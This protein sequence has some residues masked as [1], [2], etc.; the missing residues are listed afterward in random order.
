MSILSIVL[1]NLLRRPIRSLLTVLGVAIG[2]AAVVSL[3]SLVWGFERSWEAVNR[4]R[5][6]DVV[7]VRSS[8]RSL[9]PA[10]FPETAAGA[11]AGLDGVDAASGVLHDLM[12]IE[13]A[14]TV[15]VHGWRRES[16]LWDHLT[17]E[18]G[19]WPEDEEQVVLLGTIAAET[20]GKSVGD[21]VQVDMDEFVVCGVFNSTAAS[22]RTA[23][24][25]PLPRLQALTSR[26]GMINVV[27]VRM[28]GTVDA[29]AIERLRGVIGAR[30]GDGFRVFDATEAAQANIGLQLAKAVSLGTS[31][32]AAAVGAVGV[33][34]TVLM[35]VFERLREIGVLLALGW[36]RRRI[37]LMILLES[38]LLSGLGAAAGI[39]IGV[40]SV[41]LLL[42]TRALRGLI[43]AGTEPLVLVSVV[44]IALVIGALGGLY[45]AWRGASMAPTEALRHE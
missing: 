39:V 43:D 5:G 1:K 12:S 34:N 44:G 27:N 36:R 38:L 10:V 31:V 26:E 16:F 41:R 17:L 35:S 24:I 13:E 29:A 18:H 8:G 14:P 2:I 19:R 20:L 15:L 30:L 11:V 9:L 7:V 45:P 42:M 22:E 4:A 37:V 6:T 33:M 25:M 32:I 28:R 3:T 21:V 23:V 40:A